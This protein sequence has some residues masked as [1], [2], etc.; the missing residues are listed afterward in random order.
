MVLLPL[1]F[2]LKPSW[3]K[4]IFTR[5]TVTAPSNICTV[6]SSPSLEFLPKCLR[7]ASLILP[8][9][10]ALLS[11][12]VFNDHLTHILYMYVLSSPVTPTKCKLHKGRPFIYFIHFISHFLKECL[13]LSR[14]SIILEWMR[15][16]HWSS[17]QNLGQLLSVDRG[18]QGT[19]LKWTSWLKSIKDD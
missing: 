6:P 11:S 7:E 17:E 16:H 1:L 3:L 13:I 9:S 19:V 2:S 18:W 10:S 14:H 4:F 15:E 12:L 8:A 5:S